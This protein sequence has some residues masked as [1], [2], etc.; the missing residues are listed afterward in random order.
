[1]RLGLRP[2]P[3]ISSPILARVQIR[4]IGR[5]LVIEPASIRLHH[6]DRGKSDSSHP[7]ARDYGMLAEPMPRKPARKEFG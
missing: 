7:N 3:Q 2:T 6:A 5:L 1:M 4:A